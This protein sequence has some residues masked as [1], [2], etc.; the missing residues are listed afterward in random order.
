MQKGF[1]AP[2]PPVSAGV[3]FLNLKNGDKALITLLDEPT[4]FRQHWDE[5]AGRAELCTKEET[6]QCRIC[7]DA[8]LA[9][10][11]R[12]ATTR[13]GVPVYVHALAVGG[14][15]LEPFGEVRVWEQGARVLRALVAIVEEFDEP[16]AW[17][18]AALTIRREG[19]RQQT[20]YQVIPSQKR[21][22]VPDGLEV[23]DLPAYYMAK[24][25]GN[26]PASLPGSQE[27]GD[28][29]ADEDVFEGE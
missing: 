7:D 19:D 14:A 11:D 18:T 15:K 24:I 12:L 27:F 28:P 5:A 1:V 3:G 29:L 4:S 8:S 10:K 13:F 25:T 2:P 9:G 20:Q 22:P 17:K 23:P 6:G 26:G 21:Y 16:D